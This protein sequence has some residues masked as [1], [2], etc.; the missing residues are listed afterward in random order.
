MTSP[1]AERLNMKEPIKRRR[2]PKGDQRRILSPDALDIVQGRK[3]WPEDLLHWK[4]IRELEGHDNIWQD[5]AYMTPAQVAHERAADVA[6]EKRVALFDKGPLPGE[7]GD[8]FF[9]RLDRDAPQLGE[10]VADPEETRRHDA[11][12]RARRALGGRV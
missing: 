10:Y 9:A 3:P 4:T 8:L 1:T 11:R 12:A 7:T 2:A 5:E 6:W